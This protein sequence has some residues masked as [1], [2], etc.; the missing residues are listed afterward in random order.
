MQ[1]PEAVGP[2]PSGSSALTAGS[3]PICGADQRW[4]G[5]HCL[6]SGGPEET[7]PGGP[8]VGFIDVSVGTGREA[9]PGDT[10]IVHYVGSLVGGKKFDSSRDRGQPLEVKLGQGQLIKGFERGVVGMKVGGTRQLTI[11]PELGYGRKGQPPIIPPNATL[12]FELELL[13][14]K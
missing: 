6:R 9:R 14:V 3:D 8:K 13:G 1:S 10:V 5:K 7:K 4:D 12:N 2:I 11:P